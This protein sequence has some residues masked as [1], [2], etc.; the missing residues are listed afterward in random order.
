[1]FF[2]LGGCLASD[3]ALDLDLP[4]LPSPLLLL[5]L[6][7]LFAW[8]FPD[9]AIFGCARVSLYRISSCLLLREVSPPSRLLV[10][11]SKDQLLVLNSY[12]LRLCLSRCLV[13]DSCCERSPLYHGFLSCCCSRSITLMVFSCWERSPLSRASWCRASCRLLIP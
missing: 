3:L 9:R 13:V 6:L 8:L 10:G 5:L 1:M 12:R 7:P 2:F 4:L 11:L